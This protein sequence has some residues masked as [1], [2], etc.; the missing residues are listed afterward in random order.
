MKEAIEASLDDLNNQQHQ[1]RNI[2]LLRKDDSVSP[3]SEI[4]EEDPN[5][6]EEEEKEPKNQDDKNVEDEL[7]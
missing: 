2:I 5:Q 7:E 6:I 4:K 3:L 1:H